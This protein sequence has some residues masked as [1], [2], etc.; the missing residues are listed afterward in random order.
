VIPFGQQF[1][2]SLIARGEEDVRAA[3]ARGDFG[4]AGLRSQVIDWLASLDAERDSVA[5]RESLSIARNALATAME[6]LQI[7]RREYK[8]ATVAAIAA[9]VAAIASIIGLFH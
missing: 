7:A 2:Q 8:I 6:A 3:L 5:E 4:S 1:V 9:I